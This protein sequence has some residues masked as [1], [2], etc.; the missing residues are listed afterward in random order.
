MINFSRLYE[1]YAEELSDFHTRVDIAFG[2]A[3]GLAELHVNKKQNF[4]IIF[5][6]ERYFKYL[7]RNLESFIGT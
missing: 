2:V 1:I 7:F 5:K 6:N 4:L 3:K